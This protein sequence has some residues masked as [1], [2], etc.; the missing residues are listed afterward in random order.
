MEMTNFIARIL[1]CF[2]LIAGFLKAADRIPFYEDFIESGDLSGY[3]RSAHKFLDEKP[4]ANE[5]PR[6]AL[7]LIM[8]GKAAEDLDSIVRGTDLLL[9]EYLGSLPSLHFISSFDKGSPRLTQLL[10]VKLN[11]ADLIDQNFSNSYAD[12]IILLARIHGPEL[13]HDPILLLSSYLIIQ[14]T[15]NKELIESLSNALDVTEEK[16]Q[17][18]S[19][20]VRLCRSEQAPL[21]KIAQLQKLSS[22]ETDFFIKFF[23]AQLS[24]EEKNSPAFLESMIDS[25]LHGVPPRPDLTLNYLSNLPDELSTLPKFQVSTALAHLINGNTESAVTVLKSVSELPSG[26]STQWVEVA[27]SLHDGIQF[28]SSRKTLLLEHLGKLYDRWQQDADAFLVEGSWS[29][30]DPLGKFDFQIGV[31]TKGEVFEIHIQQNKSSFFSYKVEPSQCL[32][33]TP[34]GKNMRFETGG[35]YPLPQMEI[36][37]EAEAGSFNYSFNLNFGRKFEDL[38]NQFSQNLD[39]SYISTT[40]GREVILNHLFERKSMWLEPPASSERG[41]LF[42]INKIDPETVHQNYKIEI[43]S[44]G[45]LISI[46]IGKL[47]INKFSQGSSDLLKDLHDWPSDTPLVKESEFNLQLLIDAIGGLMSKASVPNK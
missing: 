31:D 10:K 9:F 12:T 30:D 22:K 37:R 34:D 7:D 33:K 8:M 28:G 44:S 24:D 26:E 45:E 40:K 3:L 13:M 1:S 43:S 20:L 5:S 23:T 15:D 6:V 14:R 38:V 35:A 11:E 18:I 25:T 27:K 4:T 46:L 19:P 47:E 32:I 42:T 36:Q 17:K 21:S 39:I 41:T 29:Q 16:N 2:V